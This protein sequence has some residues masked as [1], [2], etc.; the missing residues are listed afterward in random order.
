MYAET[1]GI[2]MDKGAW[3]LSGQGIGGSIGRFVYGVLGQQGYFS[4][5]ELFCVGI[6]LSGLSTLVYPSVSSFPS[7]LKY[8]SLFGIFISCYL[9]TQSVVV[10]FMVGVENLNIVY[11][12]VF[13]GWHR[14]YRWSTTSR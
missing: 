8:S 6:L 12:C 5:L 13:Y 10:T 9:G 14:I 4:P 3:L 2:S 7:L 11:G 1:L